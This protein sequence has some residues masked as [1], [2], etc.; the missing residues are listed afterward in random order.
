MFENK[1]KSGKGWFEPEKNQEGKSVRHQ[2]VAVR[3]DYQKNKPLSVVICAPRCNNT[4][5][6][7]VDVDEI[8]DEKRNKMA[9]ELDNKKIDK[10]IDKD[11]AED[12]EE[13]EAEDKKGD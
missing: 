11:E 7:V 5:K 6:D 1:N 10:D 9:V 12:V 8:I 3:N 4:K 13:E 2:E